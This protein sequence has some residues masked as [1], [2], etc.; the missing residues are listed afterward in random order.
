MATSP[1]TRARPA[2][3]R[4][5]QR[6]RTRRQRPARSGSSSVPAQLV[7]SAMSHPLLALGLIAVGGAAVSAMIARPDPR[8]LA[9]AAQSLTPL[10]IQAMAPLMAAA[11]PPPR[12]WW[13]DFIP[14]RRRT[15]HDDVTDAAETARSRWQ[16]VV[17]AAPSRGW[18]ESQI[19]QLRDL[20]AKRLPPT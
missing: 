19:G 18:W 11:L 7:R 8:R 10:A 1:R 6:P 12:H 15:W 9:S 17:A 4:T 5:T 2:R 3:R 14:G 16:D 20:I 13:D